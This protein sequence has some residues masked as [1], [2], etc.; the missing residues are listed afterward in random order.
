MATIKTTLRLVE[1]VE[2]IEDNGS[3]RVLSTK[4]LESQT[5]KEDHYHENQ[6]HSILRF[7]DEN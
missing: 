6:Y 3:I 5:I 1:V 7:Y 4:T 2:R